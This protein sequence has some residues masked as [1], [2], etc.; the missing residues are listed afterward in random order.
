MKY[1]VT[2]AT[3]FFGGRVARQ[4]LAAGYEVIA[5]VCTPSAAQDLVTQDVKVHA[6]DITDKE[7]LHIPM[8][9]VDGVFHIAAWY[10]EG[11]DCEEV[12][13]KTSESLLPTMCSPCSETDAFFRRR[14]GAWDH[15]C[16]EVRWFLLTCTE[17]VCHPSQ[18]CRKKPLKA[19]Q[20]LLLHRQTSSDE[21]SEL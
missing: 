1:F 4:L 15:R 14:E 19:V 9:G 20:A 2:G 8:T 7:S 5:L 3:S 12:W 11:I 17:R 6:C 16:H 18:R 21:S 13:M 10:K